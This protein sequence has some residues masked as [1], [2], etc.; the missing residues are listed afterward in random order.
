MS[1]ESGYDAADFIKDFNIKTKD[2]LLENIKFCEIKEKKN[3]VK[4]FGLDGGFVPLGYDGECNVIWSNTRN[5][6]ARISSSSDRLKL[7]ALFGS[8]WIDDNYKKY[9]IKGEIIGIDWELLISDIADSCSNKG[10]YSE[11]I[12]REQGIWR[13][14]NDSNELVVNSSSIK[15]TDG[16][17]QDRISDYIYSCESDIGDPLSDSIKEAT[18]EEVAMVYESFGKQNYKN[19]S[20]LNFLFGWISASYILGALEWRPHIVLTG[21]RGTGKSTIDNVVGQMLKGYA[22]HAEGDSTSAGIRQR[23]KNGALPVIIDEFG[24][25]DDDFLSRSKMLQ[26]MRLLRSACSD[27]GSGTLRGTAD[28]S[29][30]SFSVKFMAMVSGTTPP[31]LTAADSTRIITVELKELEE[32]SE[33]PMFFADRRMQEEIGKKMFKRMILSFDEFLFNFEMFRKVIMMSGNSARAADTYGTLLAACATMLK[34]EK[35]SEEKAIAILD[36]IELA[37]HNE[38]QSHSD[39]EDCLDHLLSFQID[40]EDE[41]VQN[42]VVRIVKKRSNILNLVRKAIDGDYIVCKQMQEWG[43]KA[44]NIDGENAMV[45]IKTKKNHVLLNKI[46][47]NTRWIKGGWTKQLK[48]LEGSE[49]KNKQIDGISEKATGVIV[50]VISDNE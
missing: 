50:K 35:I 21:R 13:V 19:K 1:I 27:M 24:N 42:E 46:F 16:N 10:V 25:E 12:V 2:K 47:N 23:I 37:E 34:R 18:D 8:T 29:G 33:L 20:D 9:N 14:S 3:V 45:W 5:C 28:Q 11:A 38:A 48:R 15:R 36:S 26:V 41:D 7:K 43:I 49:Y 22:I 32:N 4:K 31:P 6:I 17:K 30:T 40:Y 44:E 39:E